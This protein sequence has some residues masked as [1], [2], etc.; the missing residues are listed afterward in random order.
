MKKFSGSP[1]KPLA[2]FN[3]FKIKVG[4]D[5]ANDLRRGKVIRSI[6]DDPQNLPKGVTPPDPKSEDSLPCP[7]TS[8]IDYICVSGTMVPNV[9]EFVDHLHEHFINPCSINANGRYNVPLNPREGY[10]YV[11]L[12][13]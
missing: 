13:C 9:L 11:Y 1:R 6:I 5:Q 3:H 7:R 2:G 10:R 4:V 8:L 12:S